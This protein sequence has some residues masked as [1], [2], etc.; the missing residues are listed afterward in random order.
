MIVKENRVLCYSAFFSLMSNSNEQINWISNNNTNFT[1][2]LKATFD[3]FSIEQGKPVKKYR[4]PGAST[5]QLSSYQKIVQLY[6]DSESPNRGIVINHGLGSGKTLSSIAIA[7]NYDREVIVMLPASLRKNYISDLKKHID[8]YKLPDN[9]KD[10]TR[11][12]Q[13]KVDKEINKKIA[14][15]YTFVSSNAWNSGEALENVNAIDDVDRLI[16]KEILNHGVFKKKNPLDGKLLIID[17]VHN[18]LLGIINPG[19]TN[20]VR[21]YE[22]I[23]NAKDL[24]LVFLSGTPVIKDPYELAVMFNMLR[25]YM[26]DGGKD[27]WTL[28]PSD[29]TAF[30]KYFVDKKNNTIKNKQIF[31]ERITGLV[32]FY[33]GVPEDPERN[34]FPLKNKPQ[35]EV[36][37]MSSHQW[38]FYVD[39]R[40]IEVDK[41]RISKHKQQTYKKADLKRPS[42]EASGSYR[43]NSRQASNF[44]LPKGIKRPKW[45]KGA[46][47]DEAYTAVLNRIN[48]DDLTKN[49]AKHST[50]MKRIYDNISIHDSGIDLVY[51]DFKMLGGLGTFAKVLEA[52][53]WKNFLVN[54][55]NDGSKKNVP[56]F[57][58]FSGDTSD[59]QREQIISTLTSP[60]NKRGELIRCIMITKAGAEGLDLKNIRRI[61]IMEPYWNKT[62]TDQVI[63]RGVRIGSHIMLPFEERV[64]DIYIYL[65]IPPGGDQSINAKIFGKDEKVTT[66]V[67]MLNGAKRKQE[68]LNT[69]MRAMREISID[70]QANFEHNR[71]YIERCKMCVPNNRV[72]YY[73]NI[74]KHLITGASNCIDKVERSMSQFKDVTVLG[75]KYKFDV[76]NNKVYRVVREGGKT[77]LFYDPIITERHMKSLKKKD[78]QSNE[79]NEVNED[80]EGNEVNEGNEDE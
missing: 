44:A 53:G 66:D 49:L 2:F 57:A 37:P 30:D 46:N 74:K 3:D 71:K 14:E 64:V 38:R 52:H 54:D 80:N 60:E 45:I 50:K 36:T 77:Q 47:M 4:L 9:Y 18:L 28:F 41:E 24:R 1:D 35:I 76:S 23:M 59:E 58:I 29:P 13:K 61:H 51:S 21:I 39:V 7:E 70:C 62:R 78:R 17:E 22:Q 43:V 67:Y 55:Q 25:G 32:S 26:Y 63:G 12:E 68:L 10:I 19:S 11:D 42:K 33:S 31:Q 73:P 16:G 65:S 8:K 5:T 72:M 75:K 34:I 69:F 20:G 27:R 79:N 6:M 40:K 56:V 15:K 48:S